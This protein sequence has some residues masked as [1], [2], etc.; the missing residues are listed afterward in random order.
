MSAD[1]IPNTIA[2]VKRNLL[3]KLKCDS[4]WGNQASILTQQKQMIGAKPQAELREPSRRA[5]RRTGGAEGDCN[6]I[7][8][9]T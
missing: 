6:P 4:S 8:R 1:T 5:G 7:G 9:T 3:Q 2:M